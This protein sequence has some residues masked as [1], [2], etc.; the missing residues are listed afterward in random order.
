MQKPRAILEPAYDDALGVTAA[1][2][3]NLLGRI[4]RE[5]GGRFRLDR[6]SHL[7]F[8]NEELAR[9]E[10]HLVSRE[11]QRVR[12]DALDVEIAFAEGETIHTENS[13][14]YTSAQ[15]ERIA[16]A[17]GFAIAKSWTDERGWFTDTLLAIR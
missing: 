4:N 14:K 12:I 16:T 9:I 17:T 13:H 6:F 5:L 2:N 15:I 11:E 7:A 8:Y 10:M 1:F 3:L